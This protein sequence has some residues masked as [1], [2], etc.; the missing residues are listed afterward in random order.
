MGSENSWRELAPGAL[1]P[2]WQVCAHNDAVDSGNPIHE[3]GTAQRYGFGGGLVPGVT[4][5]GYLLHPVMAVLGE[6]F[7]ARGASSV[8]LRRPVY[9]GERVTVTARVAACDESSLTL[10]LEARN[11]AGELCAEG[12][13][14][15][16]AAKVPVE[17]A[18]PW[19]PLP[20]P[21]IAATPAALGAAPLLGTITS[22]QTAAE[23]AGFAA[24]LGDEALACYARAQHP[25][26]LLRQA[27]YLVDRSVAL[28][29]WVHTASEV[30]H[31][32]LAAPGESLEVRGKVVELTT[33]KGHDYA[34]FDV[35]LSGARPVMRVLHRAIYR[36]AA[37]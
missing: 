28:G 20:A 31:L 32:G 24:A 5:Y 6:D 12:L 10:A 3:D 14:R 37:P 29:P 9:A 8:R 33:H 18:P 26:W 19:A 25:A 21:R 1:L 17:P 11:P 15:Y 16:P 2:S 35:L 30:Q 27:N 36:L 23:A 13:A 7:L 22:S 34:A 4:T